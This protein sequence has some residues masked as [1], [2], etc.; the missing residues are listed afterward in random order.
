VALLAAK[1][2]RL[3]GTRTHDHFITM[4]S[5]RTFASTCILLW[6]KPCLTRWV[7]RGSAQPRQI[8]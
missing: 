1:G 2:G 6:P 8:A 5:P 3:W 7:R 4:L